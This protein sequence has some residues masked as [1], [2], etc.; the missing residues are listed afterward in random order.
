MPTRARRLLPLLLAL[1]ATS[2]RAIDVPGLAGRWSVG[3][4]GEGLAVFPSEHATRNQR[5]EGILDLKVTGDVHPK[6]RFF[7]DTRTVFGGPPVHPHGIGLYNPSDTFQN[8][9]PS[10]EIAEGYADLYLPRLDLRIGQQKFAW[11]RLDAF[12]PTD[13]LNP[14][15]WSDPFLTEETDAKIGV[16]ALRAAYYP[17][18]VPQRLATDTSLTLI[19]VPV[20]VAFRFPLPAERWFPSSIVPPQLNIP[21]GVVGGML[22]PFPI[23]V[24]PRLRAENRPPPQQLD[25]GAVALRLA[26]VHEPV[27]WSLVYYDG[28]E[29]G[30][31]FDFSTVVFAPNPRNVAVLEADELLRPR[32]GRIRL[33]GG[34]AAT[35]LG[36]F[37][38]RAEGAWAQDRLLPR[39]AS[40][41]TTLANILRA[42]GGKEGAIRTLTQLAKGRHVPVDLGP[43]FL[44]RDTVAW[45]VG[46]DYRWHGWMPLLQVN[47]TLVLDNAVPLLLDDHD[48]SLL[49]S[50][51]RS[52]L[53]ETLKLRIACVQ[54]IVRSYTSLL[55]ALTYN[56]TDDFRVRV[57]YLF[58]AGTRRSL[59]G[60]FHDDSEAFVQVRYSY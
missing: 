12:Q 13:V 22:P 34:D 3:G 48:T 45:G 30:P 51:E 27:D 55:P 44:A 59:I 26:G 39:A 60:E 18:H 46:A 2:A 53:A 14:K 10:V 36:G 52:F 16:P 7:L 38:L 17:E 49:A 8:V 37:T 33:A 56:L 28:P 57:G 54:G 40:D 43:L 5:P 23:A 58:L 4:Y 15:Q 42:L 21:R 1:T 24:T 6:L 35:Q 20:P 32:A 9:S 25:E 41:L 11:G 31:A 19:W 47:Q 50:L 29:T